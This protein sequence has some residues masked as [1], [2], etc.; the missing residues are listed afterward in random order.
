MHARAYT[1]MS[2][3]HVLECLRPQTSFL[4]PPPSPPPS[5]GVPC[6]LSSIWYSSNTHTR[7]SCSSNIHT[8]TYTH[9][10]DSF[11]AA[12]K[13]RVYFL[14][15]WRRSAEALALAHMALLPSLLQGGPGSKDL[16]RG[17]GQGAGGGGKG[18]GLLSLQNMQIFHVYPNEWRRDEETLAVSLNAVA[19]HTEGVVV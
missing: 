3:C 1:F 18:A 6:L 13:T 15:G 16:K 14:Q 9:T 12:R 8:Q 7:A 19:L 2:T 10:H 17:G 11:R 4:P 5:P